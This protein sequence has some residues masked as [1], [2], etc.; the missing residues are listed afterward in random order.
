[1]PDVQDVLRSLSHTV[2]AGPAGPEIVAGD[3]AR[4]HHAVRHRRRQRFAFA[5]AGA[6]VAVA[7]VLVGIGIPTTGSD[8]RLELAAY[9]GDQPAGFKVSTV[10]D[11]W[12]VVSSDQSSFVVA[13]PGADTS[14]PGAGEAVSVKDK[15]TVSLQALSSF[16]EKSPTRAV[17]INGKAGQLGHP[18]ETL[19]K[20]SD[21]RWLVFPGDTGSNVQVQVPASGEL[22]DDQ[23]VAFA[24]GITVTDQATPIGG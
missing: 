8:T 12:Q 6:F 5:F 7:A 22:N 3:V 4:G 13:P 21:T 16:P 14:A 1:M 24:E 20:L 18:L 10:P 2:D 15:I 17:D 19:D 23:I 11:G 9:T